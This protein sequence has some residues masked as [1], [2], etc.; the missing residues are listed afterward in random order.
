MAIIKIDRDLA[1]ERKEQERQMWQSVAKNPEVYARVLRQDIAPMAD[2]LARDKS[3][4]TG[5]TWVARV[6]G[7]PGFKPEIR[8]GV[9]HWDEEVVQP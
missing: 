8:L 9:V 7:K 5:K 2:S 4:A 3:E 1:A 6:E